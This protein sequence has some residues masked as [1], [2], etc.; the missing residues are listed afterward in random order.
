MFAQDWI[1][2]RTE[3]FEMST[4]NSAEDAEATLLALE[5][6]RAFF[7]Q[8]T[9]L[10]SNS[11]QRLRIIAFRS[12]EEYEPFRLQS[13]SFAHYLHSQRGDYIVLQDIQQQHRQAAIHEYTHFVFRSAGL[14][15]P[16]WLCEGVAD[17][18]SSLVI[19]GGEAVVGGML[20]ARVRNLREDGLLPLQ[21]L[22]AVN[23]ASPFYNDRSK[24][25]LFYAQSWA[26][27]H[28]LAFQEDYR[29]RFAQFIAAVNDGSGSEAAM[30]LV[31]RK[32]ADQVLADL[33]AY[34]PSMA[35]H[36]SVTQVV[37]AER[38]EV[39]ISVLSEV[40]SA[41]TLADLLAA[42]RATAARA[43]HELVALNARVRGNRQAE[44]L[45]AY[46]AAQDS[47]T[48]EALHQKK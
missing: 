42:H 6:A 29:T 8:T 31:Y 23:G 33:R 7:Q 5:Q 3:H 13:T 2:V 24:V 4:T 40:D 22:M 37:K 36:R 43:K 15:L 28:M 34:L 38:G 32:S 39:S 19:D 41:L 21:T 25:G 44:E 9:E 16:I 12:K 47:V 20:S 46:L 26:L 48:P 1:S 18:Y 17:F 10:I 14:K 30:R 27:V 45:M 35:S 11:S